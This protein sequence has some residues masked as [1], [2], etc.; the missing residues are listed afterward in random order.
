MADS[1]KSL[2]VFI[3]EDSRL[4]RDRLDAAVL[5]AGGIVVGHS[6]AANDAIADLATVEPDLIIIDIQ[7]RSG[8]GFDVLGALQTEGRGR[9]ITKV[10]LTNHASAEYRARCF[11]LGANAFFDKSSET[12]QLFKLIHQLAA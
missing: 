6:E 7:L 12:P 9:S 2:Q 5:A 11:Q 1:P 3:V 10:V 4:L 8:T